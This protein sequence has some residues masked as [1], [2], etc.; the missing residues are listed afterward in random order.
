MKRILALM[1][2]LM[3]PCASACG[4]DFA[5]ATYAELAARAMQ[6]LY[7]NFWTDA[8]GGHIIAVHGGK[9]IDGD[10]IMIWEPGMMIYAMESYYAATGDALT[11]ARLK[12]EWAYLQR[13]FSWQRLTGHCGDAPNTAADDA[14][15]DAMVYMTFYRTLGDEYALRCTRELLRNA[16]AY[17]GDGELLENGLWYCDSKQYNSDRWKSV[18]GA[19]LLIAGLDY[20]DAVGRDAELETQLTN[21]YNWMEANLRRDRVITW[22]NCFKGGKS[23]TSTC[24]DCLY[25]C[26]FNENRATRTETNGPDGVS[27][28][29]AIRDDGSVSALFGNMAMAA[30]NMTM[31]RRTGDEAQREKALATARAVTAIYD[32][33]GAYINDRDHQTN[34]AFAYY[35][36]TR[37]LSD[38]ALEADRALFYATARQIMQT[39]RNEKGRYSVL[40]R[41]P[42]HPLLQIYE[43]NLMRCANAAH[44]VTAAGL[45]ESLENP[46]I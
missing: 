45:L 4:A 43:S 24:M 25:W 2:V 30:V 26:D 35:Y 21:L 41:A 5:A 38:S 3:L 22:E 6:D 20:L 44:M 19:S 33:G 16:F 18:Y 12:Q 7:D 13:C 9:P 27:S 23:Y 31:Y 11:R 8:D 32:G 42:K 28:P 34:A 17:F 29:G 1:L 39:G 46:P 10:P 14:G 37:V 15:W 36:V 40:W